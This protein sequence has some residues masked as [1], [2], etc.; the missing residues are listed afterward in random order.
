MMTTEK[1]RFY[2]KPI[3]YTIR[4]LKK[5]P[6][7]DANWIEQ[8][9]KILIDNE[10]IT[11]SI[12]APFNAE[13]LYLISKVYNAENPE[14]MTLIEFLRDQT[15]KLNTSQIDVILQ[16]WVDGVHT[17]NILFALADPSLPYS[18]TACIAKAATM[19]ED[20][21]NL[22]DIN[23]YNAEQLNEICMWIALMMDYKVY[24]DPSISATDMKL[25]REMLN[26]G[27]TVEIDGSFI[28]IMRK[29]EF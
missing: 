23:Q 13:S 7:Y 15:F 11:E 9:A 5:N 3:D 2:G 8:A 1:N 26:D 18:K 4:E 25:I 21:F 17:F 28:K 20:L 24:C 16:A 12:L 29:N 14:T 10:A 22:N 6:K 27:R 19:G